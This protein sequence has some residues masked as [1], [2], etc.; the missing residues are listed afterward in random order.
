MITKSL[1]QT[2]KVLIAVL[3]FASVSVAKDLTVKVLSATVKNQKLAGAKVTLQKN[4]YSSVTGITDAQGICRISPAPFD[5]TDNSTIDMI[6]EK[7]GYSTLVVKGPC[8]G[9][10]YAMS[11]HMVQADGTR[12]VLH[13]G[14]N[15][16]DMD[17]HLSFPQNHIYYKSKTGTNANL[18]VDDTSSYGPETITIQKKKAGQ[19]YIY[20]VHNY[21]DRKNSESR[22]WK[23]NQAKVFVYVGNRLMR[24]FYVTPKSV[25]NLWVVFGI[26]GSGNFFDINQFTSVSS[27]EAVGDFLLSREWSVHTKSPVFGSPTATAPVTEYPFNENEITYELPSTLKSSVPYYSD[28]FYAIMLKSQKSRPFDPTTECDGF[29]SEEERI[30]TQKLFPNNKVFTSRSGCDSEVSYSNTNREYEFIAVYGGKTFSEAKTFL[31]KV[32]ATGKFNGPN[33]RKMQIIVK[34]D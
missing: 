33:I 14:E 12:I 34:N 3:L 18:D 23:S 22:Q 1:N 6:I 9:L 2:C 10:T 24:T 21:S 26:D 30:A 31:A 29:I 19:Q 7:S 32:K 15:P 8:N 13:W 5:G 11:K 28:Y 17:S 16:R 4:G 27:S 20:A 25:G